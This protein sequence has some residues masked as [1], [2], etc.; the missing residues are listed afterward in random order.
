MADPKPPLPENLMFIQGWLMS[1]LNFPPFVRWEL[2]E[3]NRIF[4]FTLN[5]PMHYNKG[6]YANIVALFIDPEKFRTIIDLTYKEYCNMG[7]S[8]SEVIKNNPSACRCEAC[9]LKIQEYRYEMPE[10]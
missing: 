7:Y 2:R 3:E 10:M 5:P 6:N 9:E 1:H 4:Q 8:I